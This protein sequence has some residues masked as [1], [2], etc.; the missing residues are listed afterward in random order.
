MKEYEATLRE[1]AYDTMDDLV[2]HHVL[3]AAAGLGRGGGGGA[4]G[5]GAA[6]M[7]RLMRV[8]AEM[9]S[10]PTLA[11]HWASSILVRQDSASARRCPCR[12]A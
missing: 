7:N 8:S 2:A 5:G 12:L 11:C 10:L 9:S 4:G 6:S 1:Q 3:A